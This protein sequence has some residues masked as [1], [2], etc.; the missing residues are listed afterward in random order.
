MSVIAVCLVISIW[1]SEPLRNPIPGEDLLN[2][3]P[4]F[5]LIVT[6]VLSAIIF[7]LFPIRY[8]AGELLSIK[9]NEPKLKENFPRVIF[10]LGL[11]VMFLHSL[12][13]ANVI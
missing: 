5:Q 2:V 11:V 10:Y 4:D 3:I 8:E 7:L 13:A 1:V 9:F 12:G 6:V